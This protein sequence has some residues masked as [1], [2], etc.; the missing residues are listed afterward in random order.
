ML[1]GK[2]ILFV[3][4]KSVW[5]GAGKYVYDLATNLPKDKFDVRVAAACEGELVQ[6]LRQAGIVCYNIKNFQRDI[7]VLKDIAAFFEILKL[8]YRFKPDII[9]T[10]SSKAGGIVGAAS[11]IYKLQRSLAP[12]ELIFTAHGWAFNEK[13]SKWQ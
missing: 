13:R 8:L 6:K 9:N 5:G 4:T 1:C 10:N 12:L 2:K 11:F 3:I 7:G